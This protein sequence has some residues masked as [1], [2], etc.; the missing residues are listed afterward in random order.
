MPVEARGK[1]QTLLLVADPLSLSY[2]VAKAM[3]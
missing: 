1:W 3:W 2:H